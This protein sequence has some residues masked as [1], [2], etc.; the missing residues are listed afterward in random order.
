[1]CE[2]WSLTLEASWRK[3]LIFSFLSADFAFA[4]CSLKERFFSRGLVL[5]FLKMIAE[6]G[7]QR[8]LTCVGSIRVKLFGALPALG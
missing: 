1:M 4:E 5:L 2:L 6:S 7:S 8:V 3:R